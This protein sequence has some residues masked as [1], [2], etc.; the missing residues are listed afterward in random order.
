M[1]SFH[2]LRF[3]WF[4]PLTFC[5]ELIGSNVNKNV[6]KTLNVKETKTCPNSYL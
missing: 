6:N 3:S 2:N 4:Y 5:P 1:N